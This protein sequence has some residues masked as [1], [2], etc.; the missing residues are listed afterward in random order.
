MAENTE[1]KNRKEKEP[2]EPVIGLIYEPVQKVG[3]VFRTKVT[4][5]AGKG[6]K[7][8]NPL[9][10]ARI[11]FFQDGVK[12]GVP[13]QVNE[14]GR[15]IIDITVPITVSTVTVDAQLLGTTFI[16]RE[17]IVLPV[18]KT[19]EKPVPA[20]FMVDPNRIDNEICHA[21]RIHDAD[22]K[23]I[24]GAKI[25]VM[26]GSATQTFVT[27]EDGEYA[28]TIH[29]NPGEEREIGIYPAGYGKEGFRRTYRGRYGVVHGEHKWWH[30]L[31]FVRSNWLLLGIWVFVLFL[32]GRA[33]YQGGGE[34]LGLRALEQAVAR[35]E[36]DP[37]R[38][39]YAGI[40][41]CF[42][43]GNCLGSSLSLDTASS[44]EITKKPTPEKSSRSWGPWKQFFFALIFATLWI[45]VA[46][47]DDIRKAWRRAKDKIEQRRLFVDLRPPAPPGST[48][49]PGHTEPSQEKSYWQKFWEVF[50]SSLAA[51]LIASFF[52]ELVVERF[53]GR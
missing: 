46:L 34:P 32:F 16:A 49:S 14:F 5:V 44:R 36:K 42:K 37:I 47:A 17:V 33:V 8:K 18:A 52:E 48:P 23:G 13:I 45:P 20:F 2:Q 38:E 51:D 27:D 11:Q 6:A 35:T 39:S 19:P 10:G 43:R 26:D 4:A 31:T 15:A 28:H 40:G 30:P 24:P 21:I 29:L 50:R 1:D 3:G 9:H 25:T 53:T 7:G 12:I 41:E 22:H